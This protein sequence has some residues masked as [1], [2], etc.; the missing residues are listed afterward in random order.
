MLQVENCTCRGLVKEH[1]CVAAGGRGGIGS[2]LEGT[3]GPWEVSEQG[4]DGVQ[5]VTSRASFWLCVRSGLREASE[6]VLM[7]GVWG[8]GGVGVQ[9]HKA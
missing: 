1:Y 4:R 6:A 2:Y 7:G 9:L 3:G 5:T 8:A